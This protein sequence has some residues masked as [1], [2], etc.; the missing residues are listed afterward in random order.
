[1]SVP[2][3]PFFLR[4]TPVFLLL[5]K[6]GGLLGCELMAG[7]H[8]VDDDSEPRRTHVEKTYVSPVWSAHIGDCSNSEDLL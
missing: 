4:I 8:S 2:L 5:L 1:M 6:H 3:M 7:P